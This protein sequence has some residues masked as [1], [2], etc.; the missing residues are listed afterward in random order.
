MASLGFQG[1]ILEVKEGWGGFMITLVIDKL[2]KVQA[3][4]MVCE[5]INARLDQSTLQ[6]S[7][8][9]ARQAIRRLN[10][11][12]DL[13]QS[14]SFRRLRALLRHEE[15]VI[16]GPVQLVGGS[17]FYSGHASGSTLCVVFGEK[18]NQP[19]RKWL[20][21]LTWLAQRMSPSERLLT[22]AFVTCDD[23]CYELFTEVDH[24]TVQ[25]EVVDFTSSREDAG[26]YHPSF[27]EGKDHHSTEDRAVVSTMM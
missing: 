13:R 21:I 8:K 11:H 14:R 9:N 16:Q 4:E 27:R 22:D 2:T 26:A 17:L 23:E 15:V 10:K 1:Q 18:V 6:I 25:D 19:V 7:G 3:L 20:P 24:P 12:S 5:G